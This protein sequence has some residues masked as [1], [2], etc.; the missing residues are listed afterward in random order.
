MRFSINNVLEEFPG[1][2][3]SMKNMPSLSSCPV[4]LLLIFP[5]VRDNVTTCTGN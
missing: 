3:I 5:S 2:T 4:T 1:L